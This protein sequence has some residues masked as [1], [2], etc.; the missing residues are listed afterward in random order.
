MFFDIRSLD[1]NWGGNDVINREIDKSHVEKLV[2]SFKA[3][4]HRSQAQFFM[5]ATLSKTQYA[6]LMSILVQ[7]IIAKRIPVPTS[8]AT[9]AAP[10][11]AQ[12]ESIAQDQSTI[13]S[14]ANSYISPS[15]AIIVPASVLSFKLRLEAG[16]HRQAALLQLNNEQADAA[17]TEKGKSKGLQ[18]PADE[19]REIQ[20]G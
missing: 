18:P 16:Q 15:L 1:A 19:V 9:S 14:N 6:Q 12:I 7:N 8:L 10:T 5:K 20:L 13:T 2:S 11:T 17:A 3:G 4:I